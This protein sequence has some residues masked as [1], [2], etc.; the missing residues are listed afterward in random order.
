MKKVAFRTALVLA[1]CL[2]TGQGNAQ[3]LGGLLKKVGEAAAGGQS[4][5]STDGGQGLVASLLGNLIG[6]DKVSAEALVGE[7]SYTSPAVA[8]ESDNFLKKAGSTIVS[9]TVEKKMQTYL[10]KLGFTPGKVKY[11]FAEDGTYTM[12]LKNRTFEGTYA[13][14][15]STITMTPKGLISK[16]MT[17]NMKVVGNQMQLTFKADKLLDFLGTLGSAAGGTLLKSVGTLAGSYQGMQM[18]FRY[19]R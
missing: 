1:L 17:A 8:F 5:E 4:S 6:T 2:A 11:T 13:L 18:G 19:S 3:S 16:P 15:G 14:E 10:T 7:W 9:Q 12:T